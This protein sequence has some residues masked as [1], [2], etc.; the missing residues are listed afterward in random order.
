[1]GEKKRKEAE[2][3]RWKKV[4]VVGACVL[5]VVLM[6][7]SGMGF[8]WINMFNTVKPGNAVVVDYTIYNYGGN[9]VI[10]SNLQLFKDSVTSGKDLVY[11]KPITVV[12]NNSFAKSIYSIPVYTVNGGWGDEEFA[13]F[14][15]EYN[16][17]S[18]NLVG[19]KV[20]E[21]KQI[22]LPAPESMKQFWTTEQLQRNKLNV[23][24]VKVGDVIA[25]G[26]S[27]NPQELATNKTAFAYMRIGE[28]TSK[29]PD[30][31]EV[32]FGYPRAVVSVTSINSNS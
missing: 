12:A 27:D 31:I 15:S 20:S 23:S 26:V 5:F 7:V 19:M 24:A 6:V 3:A 13:L 16:T 1:M 11:S 2:T 17:I 25:M 21:Q 29:N 4:L 10:T 30:G 14:S 22:A 8:G 9:P 28:I 32:N 18:A